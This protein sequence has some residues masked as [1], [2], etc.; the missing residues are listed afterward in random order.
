MLLRQM[1]TTETE[2]M[3]SGT[4]SLRSLGRNDVNR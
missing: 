4:R 2:V 3:D 1:N